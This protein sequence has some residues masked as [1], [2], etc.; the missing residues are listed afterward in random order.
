MI[1][2]LSDL[3]SSFIRWTGERVKYLTTILVGLIFCD[4]IS[5][6]LFATSK[7]WVTDLEWHV[8]ALIF[9]LGAGYAFQEDQHVR[10]DVFYTKWSERRKAWLNLIGTIVF[11][12]PWCLIV[13]YT[14]FH[15]AEN[16]FAIG[17]GSPD[18][19]GLPARWLI[20]GAIALG[21]VLL[22]LQAL[23]YCV[24]QVRTI[25]GEST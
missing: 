22:L 13:I 5:R 4:A 25:R 23:N 16:S 9:L 14:G 21:F 12:I 3:I 24:S 8:F 19:G 7:A 6:Y 17:E 11:L 15:Y 10:V 18:P 1:F 20:K 2:R